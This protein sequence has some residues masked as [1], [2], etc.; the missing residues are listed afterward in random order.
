MR[1]SKKTTIVAW[2]TAAAAVTAVGVG[3]TQASAASGNGKAKLAPTHSKALAASSSPDY[4]AAR[5]A[6][7]PVA[8]KAS[9]AAL[10]TVQDR[11]AKYVAKNG[12]RYT[13]GSYS[14]PKTGALVLDTNAPASLVK[15][16]TNLKTATAAKSVAGLTSVKVTTH[17]VTTNDA[18]HRRDDV[19]A[20]YGGGGLSA[21]GFLCSTG[22]TVQ[23]STG[24]RWMVTAGHCFSNGASVKTESGANVEGTVTART[25]ASLGGGPIDVEFLAGKSYAGRIFTGGVTSS[26]SIP[27][28][29]SGAAYVGYTDYCH[30]GRTTGEQCGHTATSVTAQVCTA[31]GCKSPVIAYTGGTVQQGG[32]SGGT[33]YAKNSTGAWIRGHVIAGNSVTGYIEPYTEITKRWA[34]TASLG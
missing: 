29:G 17:K 18:Y 34:V 7:A 10:A 31:T 2:M 30:S 3:G 16:L 28:V 24:A 11:I 32:D 23:S 8:T 15:S 5:A 25:L 14:D 22:Y 6:K 9:K 12:T 27:V 4:K 19:P 33:F 20:F 13:F 21:E 1:I 26:T